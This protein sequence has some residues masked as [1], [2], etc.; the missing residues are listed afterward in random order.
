MGEEHRFV[1]GGHIKI[2]HKIVFRLKNFGGTYDMV[3]TIF[4]TICL[5]KLT[6]V[7]SSGTHWPFLKAYQ[8]HYTR[9]QINQDRMIFGNLSVHS[10]RDVV[11]S[12][13]YMSNG[14]TFEIR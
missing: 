11:I 7:S 1:Y 3:F 14:L 13:Y 2:A 9:R 8:P 10:E 6:L 12:I 4:K 5:Q